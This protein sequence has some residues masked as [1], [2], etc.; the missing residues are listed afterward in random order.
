[1]ARTLNQ[2]LAQRIEI[3]QQP[4]RVEVLDRITQTKQPEFPIEHWIW[5]GRFSHRH[6][7]VNP[8]G[9]II[10]GRR[11]AAPSMRPPLPIMALN[12]KRRSVGRILF[13]LCTEFEIPPRWSVQQDR[14]ICK[15]SRC[16]NPFHTRN[17][18]FA[19]GVSEPDSG[20]VTRNREDP[21]VVE[22]A[23]ELERLEGTF[24]S[25]EAVREAFSTD[26]TLAQY[27]DAF[28]L[29]PSLERRLLGE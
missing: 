29:S 6:Q 12:G 24:R 26:Y 28:R 19:Q 20:E 8:T 7:I 9:H 11:I 15:E 27:R 21:E 14:K 1:M 2:R 10:Q 18:R 23:Q 17:Y 25:V 5:T 3:D 16:V 22:L 4:M 13:L